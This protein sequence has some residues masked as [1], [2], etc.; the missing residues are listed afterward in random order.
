MVL[1]RLPVEYNH[2]VPI[3]VAG[4]DPYNFL[5]YDKLFDDFTVVTHTP[6]QWLEDSHIKGKVKSLNLIKKDDE[7]QQRIL[8]SQKFDQ[9]VKT[10]AKRKFVLYS[11]LDP[12]Y[13]VN[14]LTYLMNSPTI[15]HAY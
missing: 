9:L 11:P 3:G 4:A 14:P 12:P 10:D 1:H 2:N 6:Q 13:K 15:A 5:I 8:R 7:S